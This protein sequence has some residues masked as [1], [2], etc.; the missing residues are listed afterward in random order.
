LKG[1]KKEFFLSGK[2]SFRRLEAKKLI[3]IR[4]RRY[5]HEKHPTP[6]TN[7]RKSDG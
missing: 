3:E 5:H 1:R 2:K 7:N 6:N 4:S